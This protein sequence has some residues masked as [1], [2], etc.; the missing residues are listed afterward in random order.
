[1]AARSKSRFFVPFTLGTAL[2]ALGGIALGAALGHR[3]FAALF[4][5][6]SLVARSDDDEPRF[7][8]LLQ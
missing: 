4:H 3:L 7:E 2:G 6:W 1:M 8:L 5:L